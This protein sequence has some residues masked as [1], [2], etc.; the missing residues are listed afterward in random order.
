[1]ISLATVLSALLHSIPDTM[2]VWYLS[3]IFGID[4]LTST[5]NQRRLRVRN[6]TSYAHH[7]RSI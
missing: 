7:V 1:M 2:S 6:M 4:K 3:L 5:Y